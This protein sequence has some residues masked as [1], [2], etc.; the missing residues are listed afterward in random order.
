M[1]TTKSGNDLKKFLDQKVNQ[2]NNP[3]FIKD[4]PVSIPHLFSQKKDIEIAGFFA[5]IFSWGN[6]KTI[7]NKCKQLLQ[8]MDFA[9]YDFCINHTDKNL[10]GLEAF[11]HRTFN[12]TDL[13]YFISFF[14]FH[15]LKYDSLED[16]F[17]VFQKNNNLPFRIE[18]ALNSFYDYFFSLEDVP[19]RTKKHIA[20]PK[21]KSTCKRLNM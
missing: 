16:A 6:R 5:A 1:N 8:L 3:S 7:I 4:D 10:K 15:Y 11:C 14:N 17:F 18:P 19:V 2:F 13:L 9:P 21:K 12:G 20:S